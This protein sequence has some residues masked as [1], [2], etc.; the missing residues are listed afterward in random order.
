MNFA[1]VRRAGLGGLLFGALLIS[2]VSGAS[3][4]GTQRIDLRDDCDPTTFSQALGPGA[5]VGNGKTTFTEFINRLTKDHSVGAWR[6]NPDHLS[7]D[8][9]T[10]LQV[11]N[12]G[13]ET[14][15]FTCVTQFGGG[16]VDLLN[17]LSGN[18]TPA[19]LCPGQDP[20][21]LPSGASFSKSNLTPGDYKF[22][23]LIHPWMR[24]TV[25]VK[26]S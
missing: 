25:T 16:I 12:R 11:V 14:H 4:A 3:A 6:N 2:T 15:T 9:G 21:V 5:C 1:S 20:H 19:V 23:C 8:K 18:T 10:S 17:Q 24:T 22:Q 13:G 26:A 7:V